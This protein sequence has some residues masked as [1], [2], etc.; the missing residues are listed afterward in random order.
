[1]DGG[2]TSHYKGSRHLMVRSL[3]KT[4]PSHLSRME[5]ENY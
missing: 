5:W 2:S 3:L 4:K 1:L